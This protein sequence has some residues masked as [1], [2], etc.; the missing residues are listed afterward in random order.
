MAVQC[1]ARLSWRPS[2][3]SRGIDR[4]IVDYT[5]ELSCRGRGVEVRAAL[6]S[7]GRRG[8]ADLVGRTCRHAQ[9]FTQGLREAGFR[10]LNQVVLNQVQVSFGEAEATQRVIAAIQAGCTCG[11]IAA[12]SKISKKT[13]TRRRIR[14]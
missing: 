6:K 13:L 5:L 2:E 8:V 4:P 9:S 3:G 7:L 12:C 1:I 10:V 14:A 11:R